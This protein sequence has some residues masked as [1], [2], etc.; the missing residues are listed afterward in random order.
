MQI[1]FAEILL[2]FRVFPHEQ[3]GQFSAVHGK[4]VA[5]SRRIAVPSG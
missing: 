1:V 2:F 3:Y 5:T 4:E